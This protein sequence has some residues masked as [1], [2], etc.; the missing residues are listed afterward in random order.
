MEYAP[1]IIPTLNRYDLLKQCIESLN[2]N[3]NSDQ[4]EVYISIDYPPS[5]KYKEGHDKICAYL[6]KTKFSFKKLHIIKQKEN[7]GVINNGGKKKDNM[8]FL[9][10]LVSKN[11][12]RWIVTEDDNIFAPCFLDFMNECLER[13]KDDQTVFSIC[14]YR[15]YYNLKFNGNNYFRQNADF[16]AWGCGV[17][18][19]KF[20]KSNELEADYL[21]KIIMN[22]LRAL[23]IWRVSNMQM[24]HLA[25]FSRKRNFKRGDNYFTLYMIDNG[26]TQIMPSKSLVRNIGWDGTGLHCIDF[27]DDTI[28]RHLSQELDSSFTF[29]GLKGTGWEF[30]KE[31]QR[32]IREEDFQKVS[33]KT[34]FVEY[35]SRLR[36]F[37]E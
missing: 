5:E 35:L 27:D 18:K 34:A 37:N 26:M 7:L 11:Y 8:T 3:H 33:F 20:M 9:F 4:T 2:L 31:N 22:P 1:V 17:W 13:F 29:E 30:F 21:K 25:G 28:N 14:G 16:N 15:F 23:R 19:D 24:S 32:V 36:H 10:D 12:D 6:D